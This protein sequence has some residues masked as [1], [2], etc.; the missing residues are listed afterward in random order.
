M[1]TFS[2]IITEEQYHCILLSMSA[3]VS[4]TLGSISP[5]KIEAHQFFESCSLGNVGRHWQSTTQTVSS[6][7][8]QELAT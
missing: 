8:D 6:I 5:P 3:H 7:D 4:H 1:T 2:T